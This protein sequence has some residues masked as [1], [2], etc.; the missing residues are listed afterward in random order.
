MRNGITL[1]VGGVAMRIINDDNTLPEHAIDG[2]VDL[3]ITLNGL[4]KSSLL[5][6][7]DGQPAPFKRLVTD[8]TVELK[9]DLMRQEVLAGSEDLKR[10]F[11][12]LIDGK[13]FPGIPN[14]VLPSAEHVIY[15]YHI[16]IGVVPR[17][18]LESIAAIRA[19]SGEPATGIF[20]V[21]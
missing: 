2:I 11:L 15:Y 9:S 3:L 1:R 20:R 14:E 13:D 10:L 5:R 18:Y 7:A 6:D 8:G 21:L 4:R 16:V 12:I 19:K 17:Q